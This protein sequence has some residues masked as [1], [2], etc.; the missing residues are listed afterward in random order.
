M[1]I[2]PVWVLLFC[3]LARAYSNRNSHSPGRAYVSRRIVIAAWLTLLWGLLPNASV[4]SARY[5]M[6]TRYLS[7]LYLC[8]AIVLSLG[9][10]LPAETLALWRIAA[11]RFNRGVPAVPGCAA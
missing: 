4:T 1:I 9:I 3:G 7:G 10:A 5:L 11:R 2:V 8:V 6:E